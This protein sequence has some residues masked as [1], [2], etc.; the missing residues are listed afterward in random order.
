M[1]NLQE[2]LIFEEEEDADEMSSRRP[3]DSQWIS[4]SNSFLLESA[5][6]TQRWFFQ[7][8][9][10]VSVMEAFS[11]K[12]GHGD[13]GVASLQPYLVK[14]HVR[15]HKVPG[16]RTPGHPKECCKVAKENAHVDTKDTIGL[17]CFDASSAK[18]IL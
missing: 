17:A 6:E 18:S 10:S 15:S 14:L 1:P 3:L 9:A 5:S 7:V 11:G 2:F 16:L 4:P 12:W 8:A 13:C